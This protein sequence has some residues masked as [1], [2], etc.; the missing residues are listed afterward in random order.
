MTLKERRRALMAVKKKGGSIL[1]AEYQE[2]EWIG[3]NTSKLYLTTPVGASNVTKVVSDVEKLS[4]PSSGT[5]FPNGSG[6]SSWGTVENI[7]G[8]KWSCNPSYAK[9][10][11]F[12]RTTLTSTK[13][14]TVSG[15]VRLGYSSNAYCPQ[16]RY[17]TL[18]IY[19]ENDTLL[20]NGI[21]CYR[22]SDNLIGMY[23]TVS[24]SFVAS[25]KEGGSTGN[26]SKGDDIT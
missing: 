11:L 17:H 26:W 12:G 5:V 8:S 15:N 16:L 2:V 25:T 19:G 1:P 4:V 18:E 24:E 10:T 3:Y 7:S 22:K 6:S 23:D 9:D 21:P 20:F 14:G 13:T